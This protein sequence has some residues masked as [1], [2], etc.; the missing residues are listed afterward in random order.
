MQ[1][2]SRRAIIAA[3]LANLGIAI[4]KFAGFLITGAASLL[5]ESIHSVA[6]TSNTGRGA[7]QRT[8]SEMSNLAAKPGMT[9]AISMPSS[10]LIL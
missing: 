2:G 4:A 10:W 3:F 7:I 8:R 5:A 6:D 1:E 9:A